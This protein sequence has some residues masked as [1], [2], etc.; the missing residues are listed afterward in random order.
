MK[1]WG[2][3]AL[4]GC[5]SLVT[6]SISLG[7]CHGKEQM[8]DAKTFET[9]DGEVKVN[10]KGLSC[11]SCVQKLETKL[12]SVPGLKGVTLVLHKNKASIMGLP[13]EFKQVQLVSAIKEAG[14]EVL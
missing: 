8:G 9:P 14:Y 7:E 11:N 2:I 12:R 6:Y 13:K 10:I 5:F 3:S 1:K 4:V